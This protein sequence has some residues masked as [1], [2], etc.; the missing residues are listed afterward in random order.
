MLKMALSVFLFIIGRSSTYSQFETIVAKNEKAI[1]QLLSFDEYGDLSYT[2]TSFFIK[3]DGTGLTNIHLIRTGKTLYIKDYKG[4]IYPIKKI[5]RVCKSCDLAEFS[6]DTSGIKFNYL[7]ISKIIPPKG[8]KVFVIGN[9]QDLSNTVSTGIISSIRLDNQVQ[10]IQITAPISNGSS[11]SP[12][13]NSDGKTIGIASYRISDSQNLNFGFP[14]S[15]MDQLVPNT[16]FEINNKTSNKLFILDKKSDFDHSLIINSIE[17]NEENTILNMTYINKTLFDIDSVS[18]FINLED[19]KESIYIEDPSNGKKYYPYDATISKSE[20]QPTK[21]DLGKKLQFKIMYP[22]ISAAAILIIKDDNKDRSWCF[23]NIQLDQCNNRKKTLSK[24]NE[25]DTIPHVLYLIQKNKNNEAFELAKEYAS[26]HPKDE[27]AQSVASISSY[28][29][30]NIYDAVKY[31]NRAIELNPTNIEN[32]KSLYFINNIKNDHKEAIDNLTKAI[33]LNNQN[34]ELYKLRGQ[35]YLKLKSW[36]DA[37]ADL[38]K[39]INNGKIL[40]ADDYINLAKCKI[41]LKD[42][43]AFSYLN[44]AFEIAISDQTKDEINKLK[45]ENSNLI[46]LEN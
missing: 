35:S 33:I 9:P 27:T 30:E 36:S 8:S 3:P 41:E 24:Y 28:L 40:I 15:C 44:K 16:E 18:F 13:M 22:P 34:I 4:I 6:L 42:P 45:T 46:K 10:K 31:L 2:G 14:M 17:R 38:I 39:F 12:I 37:S 1:V 7:P 25:D 43:I 29:V 11:G 20:K 5:T 26:H 23:S 19:K 21:I 32:Y